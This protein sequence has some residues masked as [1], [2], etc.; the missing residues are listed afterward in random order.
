MYNLIWA[1]RPFETDSHPH[2]TNKEVLAQTVTCQKSPG[3]WAKDPHLPLTTA[4]LVLF[5]PDAT[6]AS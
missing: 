2:F 6:H 3:R 4:C 1:L 5:I